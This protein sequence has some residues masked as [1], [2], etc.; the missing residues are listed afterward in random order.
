[1]AREQRV[2]MELFLKVVYQV[3]SPVQSAVFV[4]EAFPYHC[5]VL[6]LANVLH[7][8]YSGG[9]GMAQGGSGGGSSAGVAGAGMAGLGG[10]GGGMGGG[11]GGHG[12]MGKW[13]DACL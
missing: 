12:P 8:M 4:V 5:D 3:L 2:V 1:M 6:A 11:S 7:M 9:G 13:M 10:E